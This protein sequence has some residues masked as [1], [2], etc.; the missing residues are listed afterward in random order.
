VGQLRGFFLPMSVWER[1]VLPSR[2]P[3]YRPALLDDLSRQGE[4]VWVAEGGQDLTRGAVA[5]FFRGEARAFVGLTPE[6][7]AFSENARR[8][9]ELLAGEGAL[10]LADIAA[11]LGLSPAVAEASLAELAAAGMSTNDSLEVLRRL[12]APAGPP[13]RRGG[14]L[15]G[16]RSTLE[17]D[18]RRLR[19]E[20]RPGETP[21][22]R[23]SR[24][25]GP[26]SRRTR[27]GARPSRAALRS[28]SRRVR[29]RLGQTEPVEE[30]IRHLHEGRWTLVHRLPV[31]GPELEPD[32]R[33]RRQARQLLERWAVVTRRAHE[34]EKGAWDFYSSDRT[35]ERME[36]R[37]EVRR[38]YFVAGLPGV[39]HA[40]PDTVE[41]LRSFEE[42]PARFVVMN[43]LDPA[44][45]KLAAETAEQGRLTF[46]RVP[47][48]WVVQQRGLPL[49]VA[50]DSGARIEVRRE[51]PVE[52]VEEGF[53][54][55]ID[56]LGPRLW[57]ISVELWNGGPPPKEARELLALHG[58]HRGPRAWVWEA[59]P[60]S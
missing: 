55:L 37:G 23:H 30:Q 32:E 47:S 24:G 41:A 31:L 12:S 14:R 35:L 25:F 4:V 22:A 9:H 3:G 57:R 42:D 56:Y 40:L 38:G 19:S 54:A 8:V 36:M 39:Q 1:D 21:G 33:A 51:A 53:A 2:I 29:E 50:A 60:S 11:A 5:F 46:S 18:L 26:H 58:F 27:M 44:L 20:H 45:L 16:Q 6:I 48:T 13:S 7:A 10:F 28:A 52:L 43:A 17:E 59:P 15:S 34:R 49:L